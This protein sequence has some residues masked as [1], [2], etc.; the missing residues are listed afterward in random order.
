M[1]DDAT[2]DARR[3]R[4]R[5]LQAR[6]NESAH[7]NRREVAAEQTARREA[8]QNRETIG[9]QFKLSKAARILDERDIA[10]RGEDVSRHR[11]LNYSIEENEAWEEKLEQ[12]ERRRDKGV[13][14]FQD[15]AERSYLRQVAQLKPDIAAYKAQQGGGGESAADAGDASS[16]DARPS[17]PAG[18]AGQHADVGTLVRA[19]TAQ[20]KTLIPASE[21]DVPLGVATYG[22]HKPS[23]A[24]VDRLVSHLNH[25][26][27]HIKRRSRQRDEDP[28][29]E[30]NYINK[31]NKHFNRKIERVRRTANK[32]Y[33][34]YTREIRENLERGTA[35]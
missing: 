19:E 25:E 4:L 15:L 14:D 20:G 2:A 9:R 11:A 27:D 33:D 30:V 23:N 22:Q 3:A 21:A 34:E 12:K 35:L 1:D 10:E 5:K 16:A 17:R 6:M 29:A 28:D 24:A 32:Y 13:I 26:Q 31:R 7:A 18:P 8:S